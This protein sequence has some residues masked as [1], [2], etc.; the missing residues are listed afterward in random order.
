MMLSKL[1]RSKLPNLT[2]TLSRTTIPFALKQQ[3]TTRSIHSSVSQF[4]VKAAVTVSY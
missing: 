3:T 4:A 1:A 2:T